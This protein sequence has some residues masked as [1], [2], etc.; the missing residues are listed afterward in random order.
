MKYWWF[1]LGAVFSITACKQPNEPLK[2]RIASA[3]SVAVNYYSGDGTM[4]TV[5]AVRII[6]NKQQITELATHISEEAVKRDFKCGFD[7]SLHFFKMNKVIQDVDFR[8]GDKDCMY[9]TF[10]QFGKLEATRLSPAA[11]TLIESLK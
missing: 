4:D 11:K 2:E 5:V 9:F 7:G 3:D 1:F 10:M 8:M 6:R